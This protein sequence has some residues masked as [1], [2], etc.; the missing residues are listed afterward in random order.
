M[1]LMTLS[2]HDSILQVEVLSFTCGNVFHYLIRWRDRPASDDSWFL[3]SE[4]AR[5]D[6][7]LPR[8]CFQTNSSV[9]STLEWGRIDGDVAD[10]AAIDPSLR[11]FV[12]W[13]D[14]CCKLEDGIDVR[15]HYIKIYNYK[16]NN[17]NY[18]FL[19]IL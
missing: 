10:T 12:D 8:R 9:M 5:L 3:G 2:L 4:V 19:I 18:I 11:E 13:D 14:R 7:A 1:F 6:V 15:R 16:L 17:Y